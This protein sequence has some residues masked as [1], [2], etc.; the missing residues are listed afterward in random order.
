MCCKERTT[1]FKFAVVGYGNN[2]NNYNN[3]RNIG[4][5]RNKA[6]LAALLHPIRLLA[7][8]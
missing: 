3:N 5:Y 2:K 6:R 4:N 7:Y 1:P 8:C